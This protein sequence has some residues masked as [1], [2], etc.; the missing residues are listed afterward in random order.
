MGYEVYESETG[1]L[2]SELFSRT[3]MAEGCRGKGVILP[4]DNGAL[5]RSS[6]LRIKLD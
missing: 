5:Q 4:A 2:A 3:V 6:T 1:E